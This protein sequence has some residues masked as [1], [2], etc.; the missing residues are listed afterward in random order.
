MA[1]AQFTRADVIAISKADK[2]KPQ[3]DFQ[4]CRHLDTSIYRW[5]LNCWV[6]IAVFRVNRARKSFHF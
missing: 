3:R 1:A 5:P 6:R 2:A 4:P